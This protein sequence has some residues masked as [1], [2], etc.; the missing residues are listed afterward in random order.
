MIKVL[1]NG[2]NSNSAGGLNVL[3]NFLLSSLKNKDERVEYFVLVSSDILS[4]NSLF[5]GVHFIK[6]SKIFS[7][8]Y[9]NLFSY[10][11]LF[12]F[13]EKKYKIDVVL[14]FG[15]L[16]PVCR[17]RMVYYFDWAYAV[18]PESDI[19]KDMSVKNLIVRKL[20]V[21]NIRLLIKYCSLVIAQ[22]EVVK[23]K[24][25]STLFY[26]RVKVVNNTVSFD[27]G[28]ATKD[29]VYD[30]K[31][32]FKFLYITRYY[33]HK[34][35]ESLM[36]VAKI[37]KK[38]GDDFKIVL[39][40]DETHHKKSKKLIEDIHIEGLGSVIIN[41]GEVKRGDIPALFSSVDALLMPTLL[42]SYS[43][44]YLESMY[45]GKPIFTSNYD[46]SKEVCADVAIYFDPLNPQDIYS[47]IKE[48]VLNGG[49][50]SERVKKGQALVHD[51]P[52]SDDCFKNIQE[53]L[54]EVYYK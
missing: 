14:N 34:N 18:Y 4:K 8:S 25:K 5:E 37:I 43:A 39:T 28:E 11:L 51:I 36:E 49:G 1:V 26:D 27:F 10:F 44:S 47:K 19:W 40:I 13:I 46:F 52:S 38:N 21:F 2:L 35:I 20:K 45:F 7:Y 33:P 3:S 41:V 6:V 48:V 32:G 15:D 17:S 23:K 16:I 9:F 22:T 54:I 12:L 31:T 53:S 24:I 29:L 42:E 50:I 30:F